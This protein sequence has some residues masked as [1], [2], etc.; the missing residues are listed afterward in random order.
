M[1]GSDTSTIA[2]LAEWATVIGVPLL[3]VQ[4]YFTRRSAKDA[5][6][7]AR[8]TRSAVERTELRLANNHLLVRAGEM[9]RLREKLDDAVGGENGK[10]AIQ[11]LREWPT[12]AHDGVA[13]LALADARQHADAVDLLKESMS[14][15]IAAKDRLIGQKAPVEEATR[16]ARE[17]IERSC[18]AVSGVA[19]TLKFT[20]STNP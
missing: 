17:L 6:Q 15:A 11:I 13:I 9:E 19:S 8:D 3:L 20:R 10:D 7:E 4:L 5:A 2:Q 18:A 1:G 16:H 14:A 12:L